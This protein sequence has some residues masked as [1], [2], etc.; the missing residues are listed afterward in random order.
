MK[1]KANFWKNNAVQSILASV[2][3]IAL[4]L[5][6]GYIALLIIHPAGAG[7]AI[8]ALLKNYLNYP[9]GVA[10]RKYLGNTLVKTAPLLLC[11]LSVQFCYKV[12]LFNIGAAGQYV[13]GATVCL[14]AALA[15]HMP[16][17]TTRCCWASRRRIT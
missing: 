7:E 9:S 3:C 15:W 12:G 6:I 14:Y 17:R 1:S 10:Q 5:L 16:L 2:I 8:G 4:G 13:A 11:A